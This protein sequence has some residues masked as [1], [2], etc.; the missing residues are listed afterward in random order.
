MAKRYEESFKDEIV[1]EYQS[2][3]SAVELCAKFGIARSTIFLWLKKRRP[4]SNGVIPLE[5]YKMQKELER[6]RIENQIFR[7]SGCSPSSPLDVRIAAIKRLKDIYS[8]HALCRI[9]QVNR[10][11][12]YHHEFRA[13]KKTQLEL[14]DDI[15]RSLIKEIFEHSC[16]RFGCRRIRAK[17]RENG[18]IVSERRIS[19][20]MKEMNLSAQGPI[21][22]LNSANDRQYQ[23]Y[24]NRLQR[25]FITKAPNMV[26]VSDITYARVGYDFLYLCVVIDLY[27][28]KVVSYSISE[29][30][31]E[32]LITEAF[33]S[34]YNSRQCPKSLLFHSDQGSQYTAFNFRKLLREYGVKQSFSAP[35]SP[36]DNAVVESFFASIKKEDF[37]KNFYKTEEEFELAVSK[38]IDFYNDYR[39]HQRLG[40]L[41]PNQAEEE[42]YKSHPNEII[43]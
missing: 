24:P 12:F 13:P 38:Y 1:K 26:W 21:P 41:T 6:L 19:R 36:Y 34:A 28:R 39:P 33:L 5:K 3:N 16:Q 17:L 8:I 25:N 18:Y 4:D 7:E 27:A 11:T 42:Y 9:L 40:Y 32:N 2:G 35:G 14:Q 31:N 15:L 20:L 10:S 23:Y 37:R 22:K 30:I 29:Y 43:A